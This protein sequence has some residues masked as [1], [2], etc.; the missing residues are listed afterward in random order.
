MKDPGIKIKHDIHYT[1]MNDPSVAAHWCCLLSKSED[2]ELEDSDS[3]LDDKWV[4]ISGH[5]FASS[6]VEQYQLANR[7]TTKQ[8]GLRKTLEAS[9]I[10]F[11]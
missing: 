5:S 4:T 10:I 1:I 3:L 6:W 11:K 7:K 2:L 8:K 9:S